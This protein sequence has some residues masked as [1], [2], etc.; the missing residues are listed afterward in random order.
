MEDWAEQIAVPVERHWIEGEGVQLHVRAAGPMDGPLVVLRHGFPEFW[1]GWRHQTAPLARAG[2]RVLIPDQRGCNRSE[3][4]TSLRR[5]CAIFSPLPGATGLTSWAT[6][7]E[8]WW[9]G[10]WR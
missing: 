5:T 3:I 2:Y 7:G 10:N 4:S 1:Y 9:P 8:R 6:T